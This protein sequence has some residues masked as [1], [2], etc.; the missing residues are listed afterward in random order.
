[1][2][3][4]TEFRDAPGSDQFGRLLASHR[5]HRSISQHTLALDADVSARHLSFLEIGRSRPS[6]DM[7]RRLAAV[8]SLTRV[9]RDAFLLAAGYAPEASATRL[10]LEGSEGADAFAAA[11]ALGSAE[12]SEAAV[13]MAADAF[14][15]LGVHH[16]IT[17]V[18]R[19]TP[20]GYLI[21]RDTVGRPA[22]GW[23]RY[24]QLR[25]YHDR[26]YLPAAAFARSRGFFWSEVPDEEMSA[27][28]RRILQEAEDFRIGTGFV[29]PIHQPDGTVRAL[30][31]WAERLDEAPSA[32]IALSLVSD[33][34]LDSLDRLGAERSDHRP[35]R[36][37]AEHREVL[38]RISE[39]HDDRLDRTRSDLPLE[40]LVAH[41]AA[42][43]G[44][45]C[46]VAA[47]GR[48]A[49]LGLLD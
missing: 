18:I 14:A 37:R 46:P 31:S 9:E 43:M 5:R 7:V 6:V 41:A 27:G 35:T 10:A 29:L 45:R 39:G 2:A 19:R 34:L 38:L 8:L 13:A 25:D 4:A 48:A 17:G 11:L 32:R 24:M 12:T 3:E 23:L 1:M 36:L 47:A 49:A 33:A 30:S 44:M 15:N 28:Q 40:D 20:Q 16:F 26:D 42:V 22:I 21:T